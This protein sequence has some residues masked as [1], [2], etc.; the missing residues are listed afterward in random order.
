MLIPD[1]FPHYKIDVKLTLAA[2]RFN[3]KEPES[4]VWLKVYRQFNVEF[5]SIRISLK[6]EYD[7][8]QFAFATVRQ[9]RDHW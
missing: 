8:W 2:V 4:S 3:C 9:C 6:K 5:P 7:S 1:V